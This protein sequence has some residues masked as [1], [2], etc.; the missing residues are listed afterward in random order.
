MNTLDA[1]EEKQCYRW[2]G[3]AALLVAIGYAATIPLFKWVGAPPSTGEAWF[4]YLPG[5]TATWWVILWLMV[6]TDMLYLPV[7]WVLWATLRKAG[8]NL[9]MIAVV[10]LHLFVVLDLTVTWM[11]HASLLALFESYSRAADAAHRAAYLAAAEYA[12]SIYGTPL[13]TFYIIVIP[14]LGVLF[15]SIA[16][17]RAGFGIAA[18]WTGILTG[19]CGMLSLSGFF[20]FVMANAL[21]AMIWFFLVGMRLL[22]PGKAL[23]GS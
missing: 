20:P 5:K 22:R 15:A 16:M 2:G 13:L 3:I 21:G 12:A 9:P 17:L 19:M 1:S 18:A 14:S 11:H 6:V 23:A 10:C 7:A 8:K 4:R